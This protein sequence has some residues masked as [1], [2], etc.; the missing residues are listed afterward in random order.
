MSRNEI[1]SKV[2][3][4]LSEETGTNSYKINSNT[5]ITDDLNIDSLDF[6]ELVMRFE[7]VFEL[8]VEDEEYEAVQTVADLVDLIDKKING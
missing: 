4:L 1:E 8:S 3:R 6:V 7:E 2:I 5:V